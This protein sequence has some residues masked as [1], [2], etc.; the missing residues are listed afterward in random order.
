[1]LWSHHKL[2]S[3]ERFPRLCWNHS[4]KCSGFCEGNFVC[5]CVC[6]LRHFGGQ[7]VQHVPVIINPP[8]K[9]NNGSCFVIQLSIFRLWF[10]LFVFFF[11]SFFWKTK[12]VWNSRSQTILRENP[13]YE[14]VLVL[15]Y[16][17]LGPPMRKKKEKKWWGGRFFFMT[18]FKKKPSKCRHFSH[19]Y[20]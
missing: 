17:G 8:L 19:P 9:G 4:S 2:T 14:S 13:C 1:M 3:P 15:I 5:V 16:W 20:L 10:F 6:W 7:L 11:P 18:H 12:T